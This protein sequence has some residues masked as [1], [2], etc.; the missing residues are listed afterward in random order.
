MAGQTKVIVD[1]YECC[2][3]CGWKALTLM[4]MTQSFSLTE[5]LYPFRDEKQPL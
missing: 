2:V 3:A 5:L 1:M 4:V